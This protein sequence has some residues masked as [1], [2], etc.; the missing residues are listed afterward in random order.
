[1]QD[2]TESLNH[3]TFTR[4]LMRHDRSVRAYLRSL[5]PTANDVDEVMQE[6][7][8]T[9]WRKFEQLDDPQNFPKWLCVIA[10]Y[11]VLIYRRKKA[12][13]RLVLGD[14][15][16]RL[17]AEEGLQELAL[18]EQQLSALNQCLISCLKHKSN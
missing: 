5:L 1:M 12:R 16:E 7:G 15:V 8:V 17:I 14:E 13:D 3:D 6:V 11:E 2:K 18:R 9:A 4:L 10:R